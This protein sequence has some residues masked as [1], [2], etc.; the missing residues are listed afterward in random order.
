M[1][2]AFFLIVCSKG[3]KLKSQMMERGVGG[4][5]SDVCS[6][7]IGSNNRTYFNE[8]LPPPDANMEKRV[9][10]D[11]TILIGTYVTKDLLCTNGYVINKWMEQGSNIRQT[12]L[13]LMSIYPWELPELTVINRVTALT[14]KLK[15]LQKTVNTNWEALVDLLESPFPVT[16]P[17]TQK[18]KSG[19][20]VLTQGGPSPKKQKMKSD[21][22]KCPEYRALHQQKLIPERSGA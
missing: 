2:L 1:K 10:Q 9:A 3:R 12:A 5:S 8:C 19:T 14:K 13:K 15:K 4:F 17:V 7:L 11:L 16:P 20:L 18:R 6:K 22:E 21:C